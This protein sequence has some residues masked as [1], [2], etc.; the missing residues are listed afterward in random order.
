MIGIA[1]HVYVAE[2]DAEAGRIAERAGAA[3]FKNFSKLWRDNGGL[4]T[5]YSGDLAG[6]KSVDAMVCGSPSTVRAEIERQ[7]SAT[8]CNYF[9]GRFAYGDLTLE[10]SMSS[11]ALFTGEVMPYFGTRPGAAGVTPRSG[12]GAKAA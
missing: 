4:P 7:M 8:G 6:M 9:V 10:E 2:T 1:R 5:R 12:A 11:L 3:W